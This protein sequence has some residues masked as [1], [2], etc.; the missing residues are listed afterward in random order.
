MPLNWEEVKR[1]YGSGAKIPT[2]AGG[3]TFEVTGA[4]DDGISIRTSLWTDTLAREDL[5]KAVEL[6]EAGRLTRHPGHFAEEYRHRVAD[7]R[8]T[9]VAHILK[10]LG[11]L[12]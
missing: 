4:D 5:E 12:D 2:V 11:Y 10:D 7:A 8:G 3:K 6:I 9:S 1:R